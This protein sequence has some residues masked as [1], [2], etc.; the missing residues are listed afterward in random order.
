MQYTFALQRLKNFQHIFPSL[1]ISSLLP[2]LPSSQYEFCLLKY[3]YQ[4]LLQI[5]LKNISFFQMNPGGS[6]LPVICWKV[7]DFS[8]DLSLNS[9]WVVG[10]QS[11]KVLVAQSC[12]T[13]FNTLDY[14]QQDSSVHGMGICLTQ[15]LNLGLPRCRQTFLPSESPGKPQAFIGVTAP[16]E[17]PVLKGPAVINYCTHHFQAW[18]ENHSYPPI[19]PFSH[20]ILANLFC[21]AICWVVVGILF[22]KEEIFY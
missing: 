16:R 19:R 20:Q 2:S 8:K 15:W 14:S 10:F 5:I 12:P 6:Y 1:L 3:S 21:E 7:I 13:L 18:L 22:A 4:G 9:K 17:K 11:V